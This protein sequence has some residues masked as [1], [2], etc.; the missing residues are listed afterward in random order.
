MSNEPEVRKVIEGRLNDLAEA[1]EGKNIEK[2]TK[3]FAKSPNSIMVINPEEDTMLIGELQVK[4]FAET[5]FKDMDSIAVKYGWV[6]IKNE[7][8]LAWTGTH[9]QLKVKKKG[10]QEVDLSAWLSAVLTEEKGKWVFLLYHLS[11]PKA[12]EALELSPEEKAAEEAAS[13]S[14]EDEAAETKGVEGEGKEVK[15]TTEED[16]FYEMP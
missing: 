16:I 1:L 4:E 6:S 12:I 7:G 11:L 15:E 3:L 9:V 2:Y 8:K 13:K 14:E 5:F 10:F